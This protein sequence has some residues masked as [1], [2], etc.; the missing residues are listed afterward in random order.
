MYIFV[1]Q[2]FSVPLPQIIFIMKKPLSIFILFT[3]SIYTVFANKFPIIS[4][5]QRLDDAI[6]QRPIFDQQKRTRINALLLSLDTAQHP[7]SI[8]KFLYE[9]Y[10]SFNYDTALIYT[11]KMHEEALLL[12]QPN[13]LAEADLCRTFV[14]LSG[15]LFKEAYDLLS[16]LENYYT[17]NTLPPTP[18]YYITYA[19]LLYDMADYAGGE[20]F[21]TYNQRGNNYMQQ[22][23]DQSTPADSMYYHYPLA[24]ILLREG[25]CHKSIAHFQEALKDSRCSTHD[26]A[27]FYSSIAFLYRQLGNDTLALK[28]Y[29]NAA[30]ADIQS[31]TYETVALR[32]IAEML[33]LQGQVNLA[34]KYI[35]IA[36]QDAQ[37]YHARHR[38]VSISQLL[39]IIERQ[40]TETL[41]QHHYTTLIILAIS[42]FLLISSIVCIL[43]I[44]RRTR[45]LH[46]ARKTIDQMN[47]NL[48]IA[49]TVKEE[50]LSN[51]LV[52]QSQYIN[53]VE[54][55]QSYVKESV[56]KRQISQLMIVPKNADAKL[57]RQILNRRR[58][59]ML[60]KIFPTFVEDFN[61]LLKEEERFVLKDNELLNTQLR[62]FALIRLG[63]VHNEVIAEILDYSINTVYTYKTRTINRS[64]LSPDEFYK[65]LMKIS[66]FKHS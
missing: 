38:Q 61:Q 46:S 15:G 54:Q 11:Q 25:N 44:I 57:Q 35:H 9:E 7:Y 17:P 60:L 37:R 13:L 14:Y 56:V 18:F 1:I 66:S 55:Y 65:Q 53:A 62:I 41:Q 40:H 36:M 23:V 59:E 51:I 19:R 63:I 45:K 42:I 34:D 64:H 3:I 22:L 32:M 28:Y 6:S 5:I 24:S 58:D 21:V 10:K 12:Q 48:Q 33:Y 2:L 29:V 52:G 4:D 20:M 50:L 8:Y 47:Q 39:P 30:I 49:N 43:L 16:H 31:S 27:I 26:Q